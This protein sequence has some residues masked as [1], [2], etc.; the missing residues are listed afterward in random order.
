[1]PNSGKIGRL[2][3]S[4]NSFVC[5]KL[6][7]TNEVLQ[8]IK[9]KSCGW[10]GCRTWVRQQLVELSAIFSVTCVARSQDVLRDQTQENQLGDKKILFVKCVGLKWLT[11]GP[12]V[13][14]VVSP[15]TAAHRA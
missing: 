7:G 8:K 2:S 14:I 12:A 5:S 1:M 9:R 13:T 10:V 11:R 15:V 6:L 4:V 3:F